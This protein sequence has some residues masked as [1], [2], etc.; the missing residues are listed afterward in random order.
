MID[1]VSVNKKLGEDRMRSLWP[2]LL[3]GL[4]AVAAATAPLKAADESPAEQANKG[5]VGI[6]T[7]ELGGSDVRIAA[8]LTAVLDEGDLL[9][10]LPILGQGSLRNI[11]DMLYLRGIDMAIVQADVLSFIKQQQLYT[12]LDQK[13]NYVTKLYGEE[14]HVLAQR[15]IPSIADLQGRKVNFVAEESG[16]Y[17]T[18]QLLFE[19]F[20]VTVEP[21]FIDT[22]AA[23]ELMRKGE[24][25]ATVLVTGKPAA[26]IRAVRSQD[27]LHLL[28]V[29]T[30]EIYDP[31][32]QVELVETDY[33]NLIEPGRSIET[34][35]V[36]SVLMVYN[37][38]RDHWRFAKVA[39]F[40]DAFL[41]RFD[42][43][44][45][46]PRDA[47][48][49]EVDLGAAL[50]GWNRFPPVNNWLRDNPD[51]RSTTVARAPASS[52]ASPQEAALAQNPSLRRDFRE[53]LDEQAEQID[54]AALNRLD[55]QELFERFLVWQRERALQ[56]RGQAKTPTF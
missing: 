30:A 34:I 3:L 22:A 19:A 49:S 15:N 23:I 31:Y 53:F 41:G 18:G 17:V 20:G 45:Q 51:S 8:D 14:L 47:K 32:R 11:N 56:G 29:P 28:P 16:N 13:L 26:P 5:T 36:D 4:F 9:R 40:V 38:K 37:W 43:F 35:A 42:E 52:T 24:I 6:M 33:P 46:S 54:P 12:R 50:D 21:V 25:D 2:L 7:G 10:V 44:L 27:N 48:W 55:R 1:I 39:R